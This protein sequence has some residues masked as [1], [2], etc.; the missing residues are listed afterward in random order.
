M[1]RFR[2]V[3]SSN[4]A[5]EPGRLVVWGL[6]LSKPLRDLYDTLEALPRADDEER[7]AWL[8]RLAV[9]VVAALAPFL[10]EPAA[11]L[12]A[13]R[14]LRLVFGRPEKAGRP[15]G[16]LSQ[17][18]RQIDDRLGPELGGFS[19][20]LDSVLSAEDVVV[21][22]RL[23]VESVPEALRPLAE[24]LEGRARALSAL[25]DLSHALFTPSDL[26]AAVLV[27]E[28]V[29]SLAVLH[30]LFAKGE[31]DEVVTGWLNARGLDE[32]VAELFSLRAAKEE[33]SLEA[34]KR[35]RTLRLAR[36]LALF[37]LA[38]RLSI[39]A[40]LEDAPDREAMEA[41]LGAARLVPLEVFD[42]AGLFDD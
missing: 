29:V 28:E 24:R 19:R 25:D 11:L 40:R 20:L 17:A 4:G 13:Q 2:L 16:G 26:A 18:L 9:R 6:A 30:G 14:T 34:V 38:E 5:P 3:P 23:F 27:V 31:V 1:G 7:W 12:P 36:S 22:P 35:A 32:R 10:E 33:L 37:V 8:D 42:L 21:V 41:L 15:L 39:K